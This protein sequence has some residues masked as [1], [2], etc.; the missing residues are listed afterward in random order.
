MLFQ[1]I[2]KKIIEKND[3]IDNIEKTKV[4]LV[5]FF[6]NH[7][8]CSKNITIKFKFKF[9]KQTLENIFLD[10]SLKRLFLNYIQYIQK[11]RFSLNRFSYIYKFKKSTIVVNED[12][13]LNPIEADAKNSIMI[14]QDNSRYRFILSD[15]INII[16]NSLSNSPHFFS[17]PLSCKN[18]YNNNPFNKSSL[19]NIY[20]YINKYNHHVPPLFHL[21]FLCN[22]NLQQFKENNE[23]FIRDYV[24]NEYVKT[25]DINILYSDIIFMLNTNFHFIEYKKRIKID[26]SF[27]KKQLVSIMKPYLLLYFNSRYALSSN[28]QFHAGNQLKRMLSRFYNYNPFFGRKKIDLIKVY[29]SENKKMVIKKIIYFIDKHIPF[30]EKE[31]DFMSSHF[32]NENHLLNE[33]HVLN[34]NNYPNNELDTDSISLEETSE[35]SE[36]TENNNNSENRNN[37][38]YISSQNN[39]DNEEELNSQHEDIGLVM[40]ST[41]NTNS[42]INTNI[43][44]YH[45]DSDA[46]Y[47]DQIYEG[48][49]NDL[50]EDLNNIIIFDF[51][52]T[53]DDDSIS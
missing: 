38:N 5:N 18:P 13:Y 34:N 25:K 45:T 28:K 11:I 37:T 6:L 19:Y 17:E 12:L 4:N 30:V 10:D 16:N 48:I 49:Y 32:L 40:Q 44:T 23:Q 39:S 24:I 14:Y 29:C 2:T 53:K 7:F 43:I 26:P 50:A 22:F 36:N 31:D 1:D 35:D 9:I 8:I 42:N 27:P 3:N 52:E 47:F 46:E 15:L 21:F 33:N 51:E 41:L 20:F